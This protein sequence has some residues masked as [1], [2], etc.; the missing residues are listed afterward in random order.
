[1]KTLSDFVLIGGCL[2]WSLLVASSQAPKVLD[3]RGQLARVEPVLRKLVWI[4]G[5]FIVL[6]IIGLGTVAV[7]FPAELT[8]GSPLS[9]TICGFI[10]L[11]WG[12][13]LL[14]QFLVFQ[15]KIQL[16]GVLLNIGYHVITLIFVYLTIVF[17]IAAF[18]GNL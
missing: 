13:R 11:F 5:L 2:Q 16:R 4:Y 15:G 9:R 18:G 17:A 8:N 7:C 12:T 14:V 6:T 10:A 1:M 3:W